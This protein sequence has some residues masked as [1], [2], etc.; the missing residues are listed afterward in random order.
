MM[1]LIKDAHTRDSYPG[2]LDKS[3][4]NTFHSSVILKY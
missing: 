3:M 2:G 1:S 4:V